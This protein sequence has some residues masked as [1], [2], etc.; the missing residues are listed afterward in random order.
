M[1]FQIDDK[2][3]QAARCVKSRIIT[4]VIDFVLLIDAF[5]QQY[6]VLKGML[7]SPHLEYH[8]KTIG[9]DQSLSNSAVFEQRCIQNI[10]KLYKHSV[11]CDDQ[12]Q[13]KY[14][15]EAAMFS[16]P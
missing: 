6:V 1:C 14:I 12:Q 3:A 13:F 8:M 16:T 9:I 4:K 11:K 5:E 7:Q 10:N 2:Y 15:L